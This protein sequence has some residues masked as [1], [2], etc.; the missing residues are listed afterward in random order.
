[1]VS[2]TTGQD[3]SS[4]SALSA[5]RTCQ[6]FIPSM[7]ASRRMAE[8]LVAQAWAR[9]LPGS[10]IRI[11]RKPSFVSSR[12][13]GSS[14]AGSS[15]ATTI[16][17]WRPSGIRVHGLCQADTRPLLHRNPKRGSGGAA[18]C[19]SGAA[20]PD[21]ET[22]AAAEFALHLE[23]AAHQAARLLRQQQAEAGD[24]VLG[25]RPGLGLIEVLEQLGQALTA[26]PDAGVTHGDGDPVAAAALLPRDGQGHAAILG[27]FRGISQQIDRR[28]TQLRDVA[29]DRPELADALDDKL[30][31]VAG[32][33][34]AADLPDLVAH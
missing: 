15:S 20:Q 11:G 33:E 17:W 18:S 27:E 19:R 25:L 7:S 2:I 9:A 23:A 12:C 5:R 13:M 34:R 3:S 26:D 6:P 14:T 30:V 8:G 16:L 1:M 24:A 4:A 31:A 10:S 22:G 21:R 28:L 29:F 32:A